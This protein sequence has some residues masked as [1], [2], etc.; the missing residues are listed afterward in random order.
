MK[1]CHGARGTAP[2]YASD[3]VAWSVKDEHWIVL[4]GK[5]QRAEMVAVG[6]TP[7]Q[8]PGERPAGNAA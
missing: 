7:I 8:I 2:S 1:T 3:I 5:D 6:A 4:K